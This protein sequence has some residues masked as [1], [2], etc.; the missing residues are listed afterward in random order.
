MKRREFLGFG[1]GFGMRLGSLASVAAWTVA[2]RR[3]SDPLGAGTTDSGQYSADGRTGDTAQT[4][5]TGGH[6]FSAAELVTIGAVCERL[7]PRDQ[8]PGA[9]DLGVP[10]FIDRMLAAPELA[11]QRNLLRQVLPI[12]DR[13]SRMRYRGTAFHEATLEEQDGL[14]AQ[15][16]RG[17]GGDR[18]FFET[19]L[20]LTLEGAFSDPKYGGNRGGRGF[21]LVGFTPVPLMKHG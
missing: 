4:G 9:I 17:R 16:Q 10:S 19:M 21:A 14:L 12:L 1:I 11:T 6:T 13:Q 8:D 18:R 3:R 2:C 7:L 20:T 5:H 15:W